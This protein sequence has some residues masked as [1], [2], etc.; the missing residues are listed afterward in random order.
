M[1]PF[2]L[3]TIASFL[4]SIAAAFGCTNPPPTTLN[5]D[6]TGGGEGGN[7][8]SG[9]GGSGGLGGS[10]E[11]G[12]ETPTAKDFYISVVDPQ[13]SQ[14]CGACHASG[15][16]GAPIFL[17]KNA[18][19]SYN[20]MDQYGGMIVAPENS[21]LILH[22]AHTGP[23]LTATQKSDVSEWLTL[24]V[25]ERGLGSGSS[26][27][28]SSTGSSGGGPAVTLQQALTDYG[29]CMDID[30]WKV[31]K[32]DQLANAQT[33]AGPCV[34]CH[35]AGEGGNFLSGN[36]QETFDKNTKFPFIKRQITGTVDDQ[37]NFADL[38]PSNRWVEKGMAPC[39]PNTNCH[40]KYS[41]PPQ[42]KDGI[43]AFVTKTLDKWHNKQC[44]MSP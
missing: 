26:S 5:I 42:I 34:G 10:T 17:A 14:S 40:P 22:G 39:Q 30:D 41:L 27:S 37:G 9:S 3:A 43:N 12:N 23:A 2:K 1:N 16:N 28:S 24:E 36:T 31:N 11:T 4:L 44:G 33:E 32:L 35:A 19:G 21:V 29:A 15:Q 25:M 6:T 38:I 7:P 13:L 8:S 20:A 18:L